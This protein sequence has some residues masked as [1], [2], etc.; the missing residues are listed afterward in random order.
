MQLHTD[1]Q[2]ATTVLRPVGPLVGPDAEQFAA[3]LLAALRSSMGR[4]TVDLSGVPYAD[5]KGLEGLLAGADA[6]AE[7]GLALTVTGSTETLREVLMLTGLDSRLDVS[8]AERAAT[9]APATEAR[10]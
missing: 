9:P 10:A 1:I 6:L 5:S 7:A 3:Q 2:G 4:L 8:G